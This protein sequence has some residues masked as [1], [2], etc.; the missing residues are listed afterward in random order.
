M[1]SGQASPPPKYK[2]IRTSVDTIH[3]TVFLSKIRSPPRGGL[4]RPIW[5]A[6]AMGQDNF[7]G[8]RDG[9][10]GPCKG[11]RDLDVNRGP[12]WHV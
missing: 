5:L 2:C 9:M 8:G 3:P 1:V 6:R 12:R 10:F 4:P 7:E 11:E